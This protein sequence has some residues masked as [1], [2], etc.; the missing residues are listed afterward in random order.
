MVTLLIITTVCFPPSDFP[1]G[2]LSW[3]HV[4]RWEPEMLGIEWRQVSI[5]QGHHKYATSGPPIRTNE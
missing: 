4:I 3:R 2:L 5:R 1:P